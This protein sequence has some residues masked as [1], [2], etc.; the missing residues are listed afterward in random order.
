VAVMGGISLDLRGA[1]LSAPT[2]TITVVA[3]MGGVEIIVPPG[4][5]VETPGFG[6]MG[7]WDNRTE[8]ETDLPAGAPL[9]RVRGFAF[10]GG[11][12]VRTKPPKPRDDQPGE[13]PHSNRRLNG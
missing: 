7:G 4:I 9:L 3:V 2:T 8:Q 6:F 5:R 13:P 11:L 1:V 10:M 12:D